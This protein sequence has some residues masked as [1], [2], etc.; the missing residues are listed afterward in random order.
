MQAS[1]SFFTPHCSILILRKVIK[2][3]LFSIGKA[4]IVRRME[5]RFFKWCENIRH[6]TSIFTQQDNAI[7]VNLP[8]DQATNVI[9]AYG[10]EMNSLSRTSFV[11]CCVNSVASFLLWNIPS[12]YSP[13]FKN[14]QDRSISKHSLLSLQ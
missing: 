13:T 3:K 14:L 6:F 1:S 5:E 4:K 8:I 11:I 7:F 2:P 10:N 12:W 9:L